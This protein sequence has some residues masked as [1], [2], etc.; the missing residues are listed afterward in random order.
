MEYLVEILQLA[1]GEHMK[2][3][4][5][6]I[7]GW[8]PAQYD[9]LKVFDSCDG[10]GAENGA[11]RSSEL[12]GACGHRGSQ[13]VDCTQ[14]T[15]VGAWPHRHFHPLTLIVLMRISHITAVHHV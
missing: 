10:G 15:N 8:H 12:E 14:H 9:M 3:N 2:K 6:A 4:S 13:G 1:E 11:E 5:V 7:V